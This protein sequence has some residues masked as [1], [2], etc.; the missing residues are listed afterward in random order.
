MFG[1]FFRKLLSRAVEGWKNKA[2]SA[3]DALD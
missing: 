1:E 3:G 2:A